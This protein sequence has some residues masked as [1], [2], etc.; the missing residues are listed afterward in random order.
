MKEFALLLIALLLFCITLDLDGLR[1]DMHAIAIS[2][3]AVARDGGA[4]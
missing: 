4:E 3:G 1:S 2:Q